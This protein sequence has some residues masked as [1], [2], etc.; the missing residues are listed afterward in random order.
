MKLDDAPLNETAN[1]GDAAAAIRT[2]AQLHGV[3]AVPEPIDQ[4]A[5]AI[6]RLS[7][8]EI[9][10]DPVERLLLGL[11]RKQIVTDTERFALHATYLRQKG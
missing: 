8:A 5:N 3:S 6:S 2:L 1:V 10:L 7:D 11:A 9:T 4:F